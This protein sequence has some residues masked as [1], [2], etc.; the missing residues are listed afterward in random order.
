MEALNKYNRACPKTLAANLFVLILTISNHETVPI[1]TG[2]TGI[3]PLHIL[4]TG[5]LTSPEKYN[6]SKIL[7]LLVHLRQVKKILLLK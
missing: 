4:M 3:L 2:R 1:W 7:F 6:N 5:S